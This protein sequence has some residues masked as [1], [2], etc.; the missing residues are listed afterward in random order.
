M[1]VGGDPPLQEAS[2]LL[3]FLEKN[4]MLPYHT[5]LVAGGYD[6][7]TLVWLSD[8]PFNEWQ[9]YSDALLGYPEDFYDLLSMVRKDKTLTE[10]GITE[11]N[12]DDFV[13]IC[14]KDASSKL[15][16]LVFSRHSSIIEGKSFV[17]PKGVNHFVKGSFGKVTYGFPREEVV[18][19]KLS[20][21]TRVNRE[22][23]H[24]LNDNELFNE[25]G[26]P[27]SELIKIS[28]GTRTRYPSESILNQNFKVYQGGTD[29]GGR[30]NDMW[31]SVDY[32][33]GLLFVS[34]EKTYFLSLNRPLSEGEDPDQMKIKSASELYTEWLI[35][36]Q[37]AC[38]KPI[39]FYF[40][41]CRVIQGNED[42]GELSRQLSRR[43]DKSKACFKEEYTEIF[44]SKFGED[45]RSEIYRRIDGFDNM[46][47]FFYKIAETPQA[48]KT[49]AGNILKND[50]EA[51]ANIIYKS[52]F[53]DR[54]L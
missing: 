8:R 1:K 13:D 4:D 38:S 44:G 41:N 33:F 9:E 15:L 30:V 10:N 18:Q 53:P 49:L 28:Q 17:I 7:D 52:L 26:C 48:R 25:S 23:Q 31:V 39:T 29:E 42:D 47:D 34:S 45:I 43:T 35:P 50:K 2:K 21:N 37:T 46:T 19:I 3:L 22:Y 32:L 6:Y 40:D 16:I 27:N 51:V 36:I 20:E 54:D 24:L 5:T 14:R 11:L 12:M